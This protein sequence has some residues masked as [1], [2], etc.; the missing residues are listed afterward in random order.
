MAKARD[1]S[2]WERQ[3]RLEEP[4]LA[5]GRSQREKV[6]LESHAEVPNLEDR[7]DPVATLMAQ[8]ETRLQALVPIRHGRMS[9][10]PFTFYRGAAAIMASD[11]SLTATT[12][13]RVQLCGDAH[14]SN[15]GIFK[16]PDRR[17]VFDVNDFDETAPGPFEWDLK[18]LAASVM[19][20]AR[21]NGLSEKKALAA[22]RASVAGY[23]ETL[24]QTT[25]ISPLQLFYFRVE[26]ESLLKS[27]S[28]ARLKRST[29]A[30]DKATRKDSIRALDKL[31]EVVDGKRRI[32]ENPPLITRVDHLLEGDEADR[33]RELFKRYAET[34]PP[35]RAA[36]LKRYKVVDVAHKIVGVGSVGTR[37]LIVLLESELGDPLFMQFK[38]ATRSVLEP[39]TGDSG[40]DQAGER[41]V[42]GQRLMQSAGDI[43]LGWSR[44]HAA[45][46]DQVDFYFRQ[47]WD[48]KGSAEVEQM[49][50]G[51]L[52][53][54]AWHCGGTLALAHARTGDAT[55]IC[56]YLGDDTT[57]DEVFAEFAK[58]YVDLNDHDY[59]AHDN[60]M[61]SGRLPCELGV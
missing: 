4:K 59:A 60:A 48:G 53:T 19:I 11:L 38:E 8:D 2:I 20:A 10:T 54:Y 25:S 61:K 36:V 58:R 45:D 49:G 40:F 3:P 33:V 42:R 34:L 32:V 39:Y 18:R 31:T 23:R 24:V 15:F 16:G 1:T 41:V 43:L 55:A 27:T 51:R 50:P 26:V 14:L 6:P 37:C 56:G 35:H 28:E 17:L 29:K 44:Y 21:N 57:A 46:G 30:V 5:I 13:L 12:D 52:K 47:L 22:T 9:A 7:S